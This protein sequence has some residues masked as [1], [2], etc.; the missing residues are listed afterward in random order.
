MVHD[1]ETG[2][3]VQI[4]SGPAAR[5]FAAISGERVVWEDERNGNADIYLFDLSTGEEIQLTSDPATQADPAISGNR[6]VWEDFR[7]GLPEIFMVE[8]PDPS[9]P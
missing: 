6:V 8:L 1:L 7:S 9:T 5:R 4:T 2:E 3:T